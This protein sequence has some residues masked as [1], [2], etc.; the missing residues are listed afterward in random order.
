[1]KFTTTKDNRR[2]RLYNKYEIDLNLLKSISIENQNVKFLKQNH[3]LKNFT[4]HKVKNRCTV[5]SRSKAILNFFKLS[6]MIFKTN[7]SYGFLEGVRK[8]SW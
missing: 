2:R 3:F 6:R 7:A 4:K 5:T 1:M 8:S